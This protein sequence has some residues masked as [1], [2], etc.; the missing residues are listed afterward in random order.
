MKL[1][2]LKNNRIGKQI[3][4]FEEI[5][6]THLYAKKLA[7]ENQ[8]IEEITILADKQT[9]GI[10]TKGRHWYTGKGKNIAMTI[11]LKPECS[12]HQLETLTVTIAKCMQKAIYELYAIPLE[13]KEPNDLLLYHK[14]IAGILTEVN[15]RGETINYLLISIG[16]NVNEEVFTDETEEVATSLKKEYKKD[17]DREYILINFLENLEKAL[18]S[19]GVL[20]KSNT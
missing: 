1:Q 17:F 5:Q 19:M 2:N 20:N 12:I 15:T 16:F 8:H 13:I 3:Q 10:G 6:S 14:K 4:Y 9:G 18:Y 7:I 11:I